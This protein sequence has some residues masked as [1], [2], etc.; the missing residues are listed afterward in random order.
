MG[1]KLGKNYQGI[2]KIRNIE[3]ML[4]KSSD[5][6]HP[7]ELKLRNSRYRKVV[8]KRDIKKGEKI[9]IENVNFMRGKLP[10]NNSVN[11]YDWNKIEDEALVIMLKRY[12]DETNH[13]NFAI[14]MGDE[15][16]GQTQILN[17]GD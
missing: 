14:Y 2:K 15:T 6:P 13:G 9:S 7:L 17:K 8:A 11:A 1:A 12:I 3:D 16:I 5:K 10:N 4:Y